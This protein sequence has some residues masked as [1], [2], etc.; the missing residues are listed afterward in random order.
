MNRFWRAVFWLVLILSIFP[1]YTR[2]KAAAAPIPP[3]VHLGG[4]ELS[5][6]KEPD[7]V[8]AALWERFDEPIAVYFGDERL[9]LR[10]EDVD[11]QL[12][13][14]RMLAE[15]QQYLEG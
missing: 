2:Y 7:Q 1:L 11:F 12:D 10:P 15:A 8:Q 9:I 4:V 3:G 6:L 13:V 14:E 5:R